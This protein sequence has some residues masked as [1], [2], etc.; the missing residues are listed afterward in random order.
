MRHWAPRTSSTRHSGAQKHGGPE[1][2]LRQ[3]GL[4]GCCGGWHGLLAVRRL[5]R[6]FCLDE[7]NGLTQ[8]LEEVRAAVPAA[9]GPCGRLT[10]W[11]ERHVRARRRLQ[12][13]CVLIDI[14]ANLATPRGAANEARLRMS[15]PATDLAAMPA[16]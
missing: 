11:L 16:G 8:A 5:A 7:E 3:R 13:Q 6:E 15:G 4:T 1:A 10:G 9:A 14:G 12:I 2:A